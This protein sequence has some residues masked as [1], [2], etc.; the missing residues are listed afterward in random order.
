ML[1]LSDQA[2]GQARTVID[3]RAERPKP[4]ARRTDGAPADKPFKRYA[5]G[6]DAVTPMPVPGTPGHEWVAEGLSH[7]EAGLPASGAG[8]HVAQIN[9]RGKKIARFD[10][11]EYWGKRWGTGDTAV[12]A[13]GSTVGPVREAARRLSTTGRRIRVIGLRM[14]SPVPMEAIT[15]ALDGARRVIVVEQN[16]GAQLYHYLLGQKA[17]PASA[18]SVARPGPLPFRPSEIASYVV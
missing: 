5:L 7:N 4:L 18:E 8:I 1:L 9:K 2:L 10:P 11:G 16:H 15:R 17:I 14:L 13:F 6:A 3:P 12:L